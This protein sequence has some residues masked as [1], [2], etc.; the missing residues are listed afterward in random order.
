MS[1]R[2]V[3]KGA[4]SSRIRRHWA[5]QPTSERDLTYFT[6]A[7]LP[8]RLAKYAEQ[9]ILDCYDIPWNRAENSGKGLLCSHFTQWEVD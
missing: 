3:G 4:F 7:S 1:A 8:N 2:Y 5:K 9:L 6:Y